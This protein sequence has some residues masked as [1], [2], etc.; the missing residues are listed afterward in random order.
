M[1]TRALPSQLPVRLWH[2]LGSTLFWWFPLQVPVEAYGFHQVSK[3]LRYLWMFFWYQFD[4]AQR[5]TD[6]GIAD[7]VGTREFRTVSPG[8]PQLSCASSRWASRRHHMLEACNPFGDNGQ[9]KMFLR[10]ALPSWC[11]GERYMSLH[12]AKRN[13]ERWSTWRDQDRRYLAQVECARQRYNRVS[14]LPVSWY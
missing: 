12:Q 10:E 1:R 9:V 2:D 14:I 7:V 8:S 3:F 13:Q 4:C 11:M 5:H 6:H